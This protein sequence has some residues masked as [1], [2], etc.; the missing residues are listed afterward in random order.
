MTTR[1]APSLWGGGV[2]WGPASSEVTKG[3]WGPV[4]VT[5][6]KPSI[7]VAINGVI[8][9]TVSSASWRRGRDGWF[10]DLAPCSASLTFTDAATGEIGDPVLISTE[11]G[12][13]WK[14]RLETIS[15]DKQLS[16]GE[17]GGSVTANDSLAA[18]GISEYTGLVASITGYALPELIPFAMGLIGMDPVT[19]VEGDSATA[20]P[21]LVNTTLI[22][23]RTMLD[24]IQIAERSSNALMVLRPDGS[25]LAVTRDAIAQPSAG[26]INGEFETDTTGWTG[27]NGGSIARSSTSPYSGTWCARITAAATASSGEFYTVTYDFR[28]GRTYRVTFAAQAI[29]GTGDWYVEFYSTG[30][31]GTLSSM[32][33]TADATWQLFT[34]DWVADR[35][36]ASVEVGLYH[37]AATAAVLAID[38][39]TITS[40]V[41][42][43]DLIG[44]NSPSIWKVEEQK[45]SVIN[46]WSFTDAGGT[47]RLEESDADSIARYGETALVISDYMDDDVDHWPTALR[48]ALATPRPIVTS[49]EFPITSTAQEVLHLSPLDWVSFDGDTWQVMSVEHTV[50]PSEWR[51]AITADVSQNY[52]AGSADPGSSE[53]GSAPVTTHTQTLTSTKSAVVVLSAGGSKMGNGAGDYLPCGYY[54]GFRHR[55]LIDFTTLSWPSGFVRVKRATL[56][57]RTTGQSWLAFGSKPKFYARRITSSWSEGTYNAAPTSQYSTSNS[58]VWPGPDAI[59]SGQTLKAIGTSENNDISVDVTDILQDAHDAGSFRGIALVAANEGSNV[60]AIEF[61]SDDHGTSGFRPELVV[62]CEIS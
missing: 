2:Q 51:V 10:S 38:A 43:L 19:V 20:L 26:V 29:S 56:N 11:T 50:S 25:L 35:D 8:Q 36:A 41:P 27:Y 42:V 7:F 60:N 54:N 49:G 17:Y 31:Y 5:T 47:N 4:A 28:E 62:V 22:R 37:P 32:T 34:L 33:F 21:A 9:P 58:V 3:Y 57:L 53:G 45:S 55:P 24:Y 61:Y 40:V 44:R 30:G 46:H 6:T 13:L 18:L 12:L 59:K 48:A 16:T 14:G 23:G 52:L 15:N 39:V 1:R